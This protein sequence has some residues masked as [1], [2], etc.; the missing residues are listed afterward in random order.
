MSQ[1]N[2]NIPNQSAPAVRAQLNVVFGSIATNNSGSAAPSTTFAHQWWYDTTTNILKQR[3]AANSAWINVAYF[4]QAGGAFRILDDTQVV[5][6]SGVQTGLLGGQA[7]A[8]WEAGTSTL[9]S[10]A[11]PA[12]V[13]A[14]IAALTPAPSLVNRSGLST[15]TNSGSYSTGSGGGSGDITL[16]AYSFFPQHSGGGTIEILGGTTADTPTLRWSTGGTASGTVR[17]RYILA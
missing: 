6:T 17:W 9:E 1:S 8:D 4:D 7:T 11:S 15:G 3:N 13:A 10:L 12:N 14:A 2:Y 5:N 16:D